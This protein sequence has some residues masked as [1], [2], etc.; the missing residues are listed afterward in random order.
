MMEGWEDYFLA[1]YFNLVDRILD[2]VSRA[3]LRIYVTF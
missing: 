3:V 1:R 2:S